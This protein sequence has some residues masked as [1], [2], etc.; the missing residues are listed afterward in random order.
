MITLL[1]TLSLILT[2]AIVGVVAVYLILIFLALKRA[3]DHLQVLAD[4]LVR[5]RD[6][7]APLESKV[8]TING[9]LARL[10]D[11]LLAVN[12]HL[13]AIVAVAQSARRR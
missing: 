1:T 10:V 11:P 3:A 5:I 9:G 2:G 13:A 12:D 8:G 6:D 7:T 4:G